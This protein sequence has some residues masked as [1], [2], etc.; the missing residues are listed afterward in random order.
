MT[1]LC[2]KDRSFP[3]SARYH[4]LWFCS[5]GNEL[6]LSSFSENICKMGSG[7]LII[8]NASCSNAIC[9]RMFLDPWRIFT[10]CWRKYQQ[11]NC[12]SLMDLK[13]YLAINLFLKWIL[14]WF[15]RLELS[16]CSL[17]FF[18]EDVMHYQEI[19]IPQYWVVPVSSH[20]TWSKGFFKQRTWRQIFPLA[21]FACCNLT[22]PVTFPEKVLLQKHFNNALH[23]AQQLGLRLIW[24]C[25]YFNL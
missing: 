8:E 22:V 21:V 2:W 13:G 15:P 14:M 11:R 18:L 7:I 23:G 9:I 12:G 4:I 25:W 10:V 19:N 5:W 20:L 3:N 16:V 24:L 17:P 1:S 6:L